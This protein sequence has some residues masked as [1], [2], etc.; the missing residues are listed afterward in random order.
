MMLKLKKK[1][2]LTL[3]LI[4]LIFIYLFIFNSNNNFILTFH[5]K[6]NY[7]FGLNTNNFYI[8][9]SKN[10]FFFLSKEKLELCKNFGIFI[11][12][13]PHTKRIVKYGNIGD[14]I[15]S[16]AALQYLPNNCIPNFVDRDNIE[17]YN[18]SKSKIILIMNSWNAIK[19]GNQK[20]PNIIYPIYISYHISNANSINSTSINNLKKYQPI[21]C[22]DKYTEKALIKKGIDAYFSS[23][24]T[25]TLDIS[26]AVEDFE[27]TNDIIFINYKFGMMPLADKFIKSLKKYD[28]NK[29]IYINHMYILK[30]YT[31]L[32]RFKLAKKFIDRYAKAKLVI[33]T[34]IHG[35]LPCLALN[36]PVIFI[37]KRYDKRLPGLYEL[38]NTIGIDSKGEFKINVLLNKDNMVVN[39]KKY[40]KYA[41]ILKKKIK[42]MIANFKL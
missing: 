30:N 36:T 34:R 20:V 35:A 19:K 32:E 7:N 23:C 8:N 31:H 38:L 17:F 15:Q 25:T 12:N 1:F 22:R 26:F 29:I 11:Y 14:Y 5:Y 21:G 3:L 42:M 10:N 18:N 41:K 13:Y 27:R 24:L 39:S 33:S 28:F 9:N 40:L 6:Q 16:L 4:I 2:K 37:N